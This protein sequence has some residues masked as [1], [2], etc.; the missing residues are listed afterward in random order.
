FELGDPLLLEGK[1]HS[2]GVVAV[3]YNGDQIFGYTFGISLSDI[4]S[5]L[6]SF[7]WHPVLV[8]VV[9]SVR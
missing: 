4:R 7:R 6:F 5:L 2:N 1:Y 3:I 9:K 8:L